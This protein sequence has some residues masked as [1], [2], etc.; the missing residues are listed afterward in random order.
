VVE[1]ND[2]RFGRDGLFVN[3]S[4]K[5][6]FRNN[7]FRDLRFAI[8]YMY[9]NQSRV[10]DNISIGN[11]VGYAIMFSSQVEVTGNL[12]VDDRDH[13]IMF[14]YANH[15]DISGNIVI[16]GGD[17]CAFLYNSNRN[18]F[19]DNHFQNCA[20]GIHFTAG[21][22][23]NEIVGNAF[24]GN[25]TQVKYIDTRWTEWS[26]D[27]RGNYWSDQASFDLNADGV[28]DAPYRP[29]DAMDHVLWSQP[30]AKLLL[31][32][33]AVSLVRWS[34]SSFPALLPGGVVDSYPLMQP[35]AWTAPEFAGG[36]DE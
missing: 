23:N 26:E 6:T 29:N 12:S 27:G 25:Q 1:G 7:R 34:Q 33:P 13:G 8:H 32:S 17:R 5:S 9:V 11:H 3:S 16:D 30:S 21:S 4:K 18:N 15:S 36:F 28:A 31:G 22:Q 24:V 2:V 14:N 20:T 10:Q 19:R 35:P